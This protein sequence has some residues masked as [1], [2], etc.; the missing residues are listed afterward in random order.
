MR[1]FIFKIAIFAL[2]IF[3]VDRGIGVAMTYF[4]NHAIGGYV[5]HH[6]YIN[7]EMSKDILIFGSSRAV[8]HYDAKMISD[9]LGL[10]CY[11][12]GQDGNGIILNYG[13]WLMIK[14][15]CHPRLI[16][17]DIHDIYDISEGETNTKYLGWLK[18]Y[19]ERNGISDIFEDVDESE[20][21]KMMSMMYRNNSKLLQIMSDYLY[22]VYKI[23]SYGFL[24]MD[25]KM[26][27]MQ[28]RKRKVKDVIAKNPK[29][30]SLKIFYFEKFVK[31]LGDTKLLVSISPLWYGMEDEKKIHIKNLCKRYNIILIDFSNNKKY[32]KNNDYFYNGTHLNALGAEE[33]T[34]DFISVIHNELE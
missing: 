28:V 12:C 26:D 18:P 24:P 33:F 5:A 21:W 22:P 2:I 32:V 30:D 13:Q 34:K 29:V 10:S 1:K 20:K 9:S 14:E 25:L 4:S 17:Y 31:S 6:N 11:N 15:H 23:D 27:T 8:H 7:N 19:Y 3:A 16:I